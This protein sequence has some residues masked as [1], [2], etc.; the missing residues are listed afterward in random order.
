MIEDQRVK[1]EEL[2]KQLIQAEEEKE[3]LRI[4][5]G[6]VEKSQQEKWLLKK[7][8]NQAYV[9]TN[10]IKMEQ[11]RA[12]QAM[13]IAEDKIVE[14]ID[15]N[16][17]LQTQKLKA[18]GRLDTLRKELASK[19]EKCDW[20]EKREDELRQEGRDIREALKGQ[21]RK[22]E[23]EM[24]LLKEAKKGLEDKCEMLIF[25]KNEI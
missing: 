5:L 25:H 22:K 9:E 4:E 12:N 20:L 16:G 2:E 7:K 23:Q 24:Y 6:Q 14:L 13:S 8:I 19:E 3:D 11:E 21:I 15:K 18:E 10:S 1:L 17:K